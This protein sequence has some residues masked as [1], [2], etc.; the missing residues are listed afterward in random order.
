M[1]V[2][3]PTLHMFM[4]T[5]II[6]YMQ[7]FQLIMDLDWQIHLAT[8]FP[9]RHI[10]MIF[11]YF[12]KTKISSLQSSHVHVSS[13]CSPAENIVIGMLWWSSIENNSSYPSLKKVNRLKTQ[14]LQCADK[15]P[16]PS[17]LSHRILF[18]PECYISILHH[19]PKLILPNL[20]F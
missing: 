6:V 12:S 13:P 10:G 19:F 17:S 11:Y 15:L 5:I 1:N 20:I 18:S 3:L 4:Y 9:Y 7:T 2:F 16:Q 8:F 14:A